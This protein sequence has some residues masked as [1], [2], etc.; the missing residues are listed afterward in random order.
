MREVDGLSG[1]A[2]IWHDF[3]R[4][5]LSGAQK[6]EFI[7]PPGIT[8]VEVCTLS[9]LLPS[10]ACPYRKMEWFIEATQPVIEDHFYKLVD[11]DMRTR[12]MAQ[13]DTPLE[14]RRE[15]LALDLPVQ[16]RQWALAQGITLYTDL[17]EASGQQGGASTAVAIHISSPADGSQYHLST[18]ADA[19]SQKIKIEVVGPFDLSQIE[20]MVDQQVVQTLSGAPFQTW[21]TLEPGSH[22]IWATGVTHSGVKLNSEPVRV[23]V[24]DH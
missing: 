20:I 14:Y 12:V 11:V 8:P 7:Q 13:V 23:M 16:A 22:Q 24:F 2:P 5:A 17:L 19:D 15:S 6:R 10:E 9:G 18:Y 21:W 4:A 1:A 3:M